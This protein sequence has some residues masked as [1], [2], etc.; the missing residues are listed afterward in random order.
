MYL[1]LPLL[2]LYFVSFSFSLFSKI[3]LR[4]A[5][6]AGER[7]PEFRSFAG[8]RSLISDFEFVQIQKC[9]LSL[10]A[11]SVVRVVH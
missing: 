7:A 3:S 2:V 9:L 8:A 1:F 11:Q 6:A 5:R 4:Q 10:C